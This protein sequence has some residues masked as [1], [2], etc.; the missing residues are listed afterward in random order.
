VPSKDDVVIVL[1]GAS[2]FDHAVK[3]LPH[4]VETFAYVP[5]QVMGTLSIAALLLRFQSLV[6]D[7]VHVYCNIVLLLPK[8]KKPG[9][10]SAR[11]SVKIGFRQIF[12]IALSYTSRVTRSMSFSDTSFSDMSFSDIVGS[13]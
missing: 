10:V 6:S 3:A 9:A 5:S 8:S 13:T 1:I 2:L 12:Q 4:L 11:A 7:R